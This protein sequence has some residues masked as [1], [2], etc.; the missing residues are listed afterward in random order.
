MATLAQLKTRIMLDTARDDL[1]VGGELAQAL[2]DAIAD[3]VEAYAD[4]PFWFNRASGN[5]SITV[6]G[7]TVALPAG[8]RSAGLVSRDGV[9]LRKVPLASLQ[10]RSET[11]YPSLWAEEGGALR[12]WPIPDAGYTLAL[13]GIAELGL[14]ED[15]DTANAWTQEG[16]RLILACAKKILYR[17]SLRDP[18]GMALARDEEQE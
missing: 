16:G 8:M 2:A 17:G 15:P 18:D 7:G 13:F 3:A 10:G 1:G 5:V 11:G 14:P 9:A 4:E 6:S 12:L